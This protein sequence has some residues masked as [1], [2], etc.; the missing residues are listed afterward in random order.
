MSF[1]NSDTA[2]KANAAAAAIVSNLPQLKPVSSTDTAST[3]SELTA[4]NA[5]PTRVESVLK[6]ADLSPEAVTT[7]LEA[8]ALACVAEKATSD[9][10]QEKEFTSNDVL[11]GRGGLTNNAPG[12]IFFRKLVRMKQ[13]VYL[14]ASKREKAG[15]AREI[16][17][18]I[19]SLN[20]PGRFLKKD[21]NGVYKDIGDRKARE[22]TSQALREGAPNIRQGLGGN[23]TTTLPSGVAPIKMTLEESTYIMGQPTNT[24]PI[25][26]QPR[27]FL[28]PNPWT[29][30]SNRARVVSDDSVGIQ[31]CMAEA[32]EGPAP[33]SAGS[34]RK[35]GCALEEKRPDEAHV[36][37]RGPR[38]LRFKSR[39]M[40]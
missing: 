27:K 20:P 33:Y 35:V 23:T 1:I 26:H 14:L 21:S 9:E 37:P 30:P 4:E 10:Q 11:C 29:M 24:A 15:V 36:V 2:L 8:L 28:K 5:P 17:E 34:K 40:T 31:A 38:L 12:N 18:T 22:K 6:A 19:R 32:Q 16:V 3:S 7:P 13:Q 25:F 39:L